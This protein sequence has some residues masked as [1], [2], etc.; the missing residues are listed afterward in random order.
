MYTFNRPTD[1]AA[2]TP[3]AYTCNRCIFSLGPSNTEANRCVAGYALRDHALASIEPP[4]SLKSEPNLSS[5]VA[6]QM[7]GGGVLYVEQT[8]PRC[9]SCISSFS[10]CF[11]FFGSGAV[12]TAP[13]H[14]ILL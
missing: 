4:V 8:R 7:A 3:C 14:T 6:G 1:T 12:F 10:L 2:V 11:F 13:H 9:A 5:H